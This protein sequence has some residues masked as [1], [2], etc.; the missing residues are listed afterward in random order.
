MFL[1]PLHK[2]GY[3]RMSKYVIQ[4][5]EPPIA[6]DRLLEARFKIGHEPNN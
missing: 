5:V 1:F 6:T 2:V 4:D 3:R